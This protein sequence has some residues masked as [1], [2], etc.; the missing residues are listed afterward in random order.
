MDARARDALIAVIGR[1]RDRGAAVILATHDN[2][3]RTAVADRVLSV[4]DG[5]VVEGPQ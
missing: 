2:A 3:L 4:A 1:L 5:R